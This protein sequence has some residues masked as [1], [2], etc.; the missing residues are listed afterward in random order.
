MCPPCLTPFAMLHKTRHPL[1]PR[2]RHRDG[3]AV[4]AASDMSP[5]PQRTD[6]PANR[7]RRADLRMAW[8]VLG[9]AGLACV[10]AVVAAGIGPGL[11]APPEPP[12]TQAA[13]QAQVG[14]NFA[15]ALD[16]QRSLDI[17]QEIDAAIAQAQTAKA[18]AETA[19]GE[20]RAVLERARAALA[21]G[22]A[23]LVRQ[24]T[25]EGY[26]YEGEAE[27]GRPQGYG[28][29]QRPNGG[30]GASYFIDGES[31]GPGVSC[32]SQSCQGASYF[33]DYRHNAPTGFGVG[34]SAD[35][36]AYR[37]E[38]KGG[39]P[40][41]YGEYVYANGAVYRGGFEA[42]ARQGY[43][44]LRTRDGALQA[45]YWRKN[46]LIAPTDGARSQTLPPAGDAR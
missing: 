24:R 6:H 15:A 10:G 14:A 32:S 5:S 8:V 25:P 45:G 23:N 33:G 34:V 9:V 1:R 12:K 30:F 40:D 38:F 20:A 29:V 11:L 4:N 21:G 41:G 43:G 37:G 17:T 3:L 42:G 22:G 31:R 39:L 18:R 19:A 35:G 2:A 44:A 36:G 26:L 27:S 13:V 46:A 7:R 16:A 28:L